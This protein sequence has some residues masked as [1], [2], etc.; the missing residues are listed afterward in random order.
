MPTNQEGIVNTKIVDTMIVLLGVVM[1]VVGAVLFYIG[2][3]ADPTDMPILVTGIVI[4]FIGLVI[5][6]AK[7]G[8]PRFFVELIGDILEGIFD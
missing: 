5:L 7:A 6:A 1:T 4:A 2:F 8:L 3:S